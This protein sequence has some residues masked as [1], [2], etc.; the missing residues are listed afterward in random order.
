MALEIPILENDRVPSSLSLCDHGAK[1]Q[2]LAIMSTSITTK[3]SCCTSL[4]SSSND[5]S[6]AS[7]CWHKV[8]VT[9]QSLT[10][11]GYF[12][13]RESSTA[14]AMVAFGES[15][16]QHKEMQV[17]S[18]VVC[19][20]TGHLLVESEADPLDASTIV[21]PDQPHMSMYIP[22]NNNNESEP[23][24]PPREKSTFQRSLSSKHSSGSPTS[25]METQMVNSFD[26]DLSR[27]RSQVEEDA[28]ERIVEL[29]VRLG[30]Q[31]HASS[32]DWDG[33]AY[34]R[35]PSH[36]GRHSVSLPLQKPLT[37]ARS[38]DEGNIRDER[39][40]L[41]KAY[42]QLSVDVR[43]SDYVP[44]LD[45]V[46]P[47]PDFV[48]PPPPPPMN[49]T[50]S[51]MERKI[52]SLLNHIQA[53]EEQAQRD[54]QAQRRQMHVQVPSVP[55][56]QRKWTMSSLWENFLCSCDFGNSCLS[57]CTHQY[58]PDDVSLTDNSTIATR[59]SMAI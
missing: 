12:S 31:D 50:R 8:H 24:S 29:F 5:R 23:N 4:N 42:L 25:P 59:A 57:P 14:P 35:V 19:N 54:F 18:S 1:K 6:E 45:M 13:S 27:K 15:T 32:S 10:N 21:W 30:R 37:C 16:M 11:V 9:I 41:C 33:V 55:Q 46:S 7:A 3:T 28:S 44:A 26:G 49:L 53:N 43:E 38:S 52:G 39:F 36:V 58:D 34:L 40:S 48:P 22:S 20:H 47:L 51:T 56:T 17:G 2:G